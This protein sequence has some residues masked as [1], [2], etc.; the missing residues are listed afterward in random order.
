MDFELSNSEDTLL[1]FAVS[2]KYT[3]INSLIKETNTFIKNKREIDGTD[4]FNFIAFEE[5][6]PVY[7]EDFL[8][9]QEYIIDAMKGMKWGQPNTSGGIFLAITFI[10]D[11]FKLVSAKTFRLIVIMDKSAPGIAN[12]EVVLDL[13]HQVEDMPFFIEFVRIDI[14]DPKA[15][16]EII[17]FAKRCN[18]EVYQADNESSGLRKV[19]QKLT[20]KRKIEGSILL[21][22]RSDA[23]IANS[24]NESFYENLAS[25][26]QYL[27]NERMKNSI[28]HIC[29]EKGELIE[30]PA[31][32]SES[33]AACLAMWGQNSNIGVP[34]IFRCDQ[35]FNLLKL[36]RDFV[37]DV[38]SG[39]FMEILKKQIAFKPKDQ[40]EFL[41]EKE[42]RAAPSLKTGEDPFGMLLDNFQ[43]QESAEQARQSSVEETGWLDYDSDFKFEDDSEL[44]VQMCDDCLKLIAPEWKN[45]P[46]CGK[47][48]K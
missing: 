5:L 44:R 14:D 32:K 19:F 10:I 15:D 13:V 34:H 33:H 1:F 42:A 30:C 11:V 40:H 38:Q 23:H 29:R 16:L 37:Q 22:T 48:M 21:K 3:N 39:K 27:D 26:L 18:G 25:D 9:E 4:R 46:Y 36:P 12:P 24:S 2:P 6:G 43:A 8:Y 35:C 17:R 28:C 47:K 20:Q 31:C 41:K 7:F 45:C